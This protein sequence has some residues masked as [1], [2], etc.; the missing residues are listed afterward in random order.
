V[1]APSV[2]P[3]HPALM[4]LLGGVLACLLIGLG[5]ALQAR[6]M[7]HGDP[8]AQISGPSS[9]VNLSSNNAIVQAVQRVGP[10]VMNVDTTFGQNSAALLADP[11]DGATPREGKGTGVVYDSKRGLMLTNAHVIAPNGEPAKKIQVT[12]RDGEQYTGRLVGFDRFTDIA[13]V[14]LSNKNLPA[15]RLAKLKNARDLAIGQWAIAIGNPFAQANT[16]TVGVI[17]AVGRNIP[18]PDGRNG[19]SFQISDM[20]QTDA[21]INPGNSGGP[22]CNVQGEVIGINTAIIPF[23]TGLGFSIPINKAKQVA[24]QLVKNGGKTPYIGIEM[25]P[26]TD[27]VKKDYGMPDKN[28]AFVRAVVPATPA[29]TARVQARD[30][31]RAVDGQKVKTSQDV[32]D[33]IRRKQVGQSVRLEVLRNKRVKKTLTLTIDAQPQGR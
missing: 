22:L 1:V 4:L 5:M 15:A 24:D 21:A 6:R 10:S 28:G 7:T 32:V 11:H 29:A 12:T 14:E 26:V 20:I 16:V 9:G 33:A 31:V 17:S 2:A 27:D 25:I 23:G 18:V 3:L 8:L 19:R 30:V 13:V